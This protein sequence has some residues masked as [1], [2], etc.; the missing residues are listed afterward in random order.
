MIGTLRTLLREDVGSALIELALTVG[1]LGVPLLLGTGALAPLAYASVEVDNAAHAA[2]LYG[3][4]S[5]TFAADNAGITSAAQAEATD[6]NTSLTVV[7]L[8]FYAC[9]T[10]IGGTHYTGNNAQANATSACT[11]TNNHSLQF[12]Q[13][14]AMLKVTPVIRC[15]GLSTTFTLTGTSV[16]EVQQ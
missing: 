14:K 1:L 13:V 8:V 10:A 7:P 11:G 4:Q 9:A 6:Y 15:P 2:A 16:M 5:P 3:S 12:V